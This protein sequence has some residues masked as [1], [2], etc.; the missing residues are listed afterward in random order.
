[1]GAQG[2]QPKPSVPTPRTAPAQPQRTSQ[3]RPRTRR[4]FSSRPPFRG[5]SER[6]RGGQRTLPVD[7][8]P[9]R[10]PARKWR[11]RRSGASR[12]VRAARQLDRARQSYERLLRDYAS[13]PVGSGRPGAADRASRR[14]GMG[15][16]RGQQGRTAAGGFLQVGFEA[17]FWGVVCDSRFFSDLAIYDL[18]RLARPAGAQ[19]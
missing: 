1:M 8:E 14:R 2:G 6:D 5:S 3:G 18:R 16:T 9:I 15:R 11:L 12:S 4:L 19:W 17:P 10:R 13:Q 7:R